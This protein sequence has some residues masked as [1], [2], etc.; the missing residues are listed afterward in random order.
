MSSIDQRIVEMKFDNKQFEKGIQTSLS[1]LSK[2]KNGLKFDKIKNGIN[3]T[4][5]S[6]KNLAHQFTLFGQ[7]ALKVKDTIADLVVNRGKQLVKSLTIDQVSSGWTKY[8][9]KTASVQT[10]MN[11]TGKSIDE[12]N[13]YLD[14]LMWFSDETSYSFTEM[15]SAL[16]TMTS[17]GGDINKLIPMIE[18][19]A[20]ATSFAGKGAAEFSRLIY[21]L[22]Q[23]YGQGYLSL[24]DWK[25]I[26][27]ANV[28]SEQ[29][30]QTI[31]DTAVALG[32]LKKD[33]KGVIRTTK[34]TV[35][36]AANMASTLNEKWATREVME[37]AFGQFGAVF[38]D[39]YELV[40]A[41]GGTAA[42]AIASLAG[43]YDDVYYNAAKAA[44]EAKTFTE[45]IVSTK[46][47]VSSGWMKTFEIIFGNYEEAKEM[48]TNLANFLWEAFASGSESRNK[49]M[50]EWKELG[51][52]DDLIKGVGNSL[53]AILNIV[54]A[55]K[56]GIAEIFPSPDAT[57]LVALTKKVKE[58]GDML[59]RLSGEEYSETEVEVPVKV[60]PDPEALKRT[61][62]RDM[63][64]DDVK[65]LQERLTSLGYSITDFELGRG[66]FGVAT[67]D[68]LKQF[69]KDLGLAA[70]GVYNEDVHEVLWNK[71]FPPTETTRVEKTIERVSVFSSALERLKRVA[72]GVA[73]AAD[74]LWKGIKFVGTVAFSVLKVLAPLADALLTILAAIGDCFVALD[75]GLGVSEL[76]SG[77]LA[78]I[79]G[80]LEPV[81]KGV[82]K[83]SDALL[84]FFGLGKKENGTN[85]SLMTFSKLW[86]NIKGKLKDWGVWD[87]LT[88]AW[89]RLSEAAGK[90]GNAFKRL[91]ASIKVAWQN[92]KATI[93]E[94]FPTLFDKTKTGAAN[95]WSKSITAIGIGLSKAIDFIT[96]IIQKLP[97]IKSKVTEFAKTA[98]TFLTDLWSRLE[99]SEKFGGIAARISNFFRTLWNAVSEFFIGGR[100]DTSSEEAKA[101][102]KLSI[103]AKIAETLKNGWDKVSS[104]FKWVYNGITT[105]WRKIGGLDGIIDNAWSLVALFG[106]FSGVK[107]LRS[108]SGFVKSISKIALG[109]PSILKKIPEFIENAGGVLESVSDYVKHQ[110]RKNALKN[111]ASAAKD[112]ALAIGIL[113][114]SIYVLGK[115]SPDELK[116][117]GIALAGIAFGLFLLQLGFAKLAKVNPDVKVQF[118]GFFSLALAVLT[119][120][121]V[122]KIINRMSLEDYLKGAARVAGMILALRLIMLGFGKFKKTNVSIKGMLSVSFALLALLRVMKIVN[123][124]KSSEYWTGLARVAGMILALRL[125]ML[126][127]GKFKKTNVS[128]KGL[129]SLSFSL[130]ALVGVIKL[131]SSMDAGDYW[132]GLLG[133]SGLMLALALFARS[134]SRLKTRG[135]AKKAVSLIAI[136]LTIRILARTMAYIGRLDFKT[137][138]LG[139]IGLTTIMLLLKAVMKA[140][141]RLNPKR[142]FSAIVLCLGIVALMRE[143]ARALRSVEDVDYRKTKW[144]GLGITGILASLSMVMR[145]S[146][147]FRFSGIAKIFLTIV[148]I[149]AAV[150]L[151]IA[152]FAELKKIPGFQE[153]MNSGAASL[154]EIV[155]SFLGGMH[156][157]EI[158]TF[159]NLANDVDEKA[160]ERALSLANKLSDFGKKLPSTSGESS[161]LSYFQKSPLAQFSGD[162]STFGK[163]FSEFAKALNDIGTEKYD[164]L[165]TKAGTA[166]DIA[167]SLAKF[168]SE[169]VEMPENT[170]S[171]PF[172]WIRES[173]LGVFSDDIGDF[174]GGFGT[175]ASM[176][177]LV[178]P[179]EYD[180]LEGKA[181]TALT[182]AKGLAAFSNENVEMPENTYTGPFGWIRKSSLE[183]FSEDFGD[184]GAEFNKFANKMSAVDA[185]DYD[186]LEGKA[187]TALTI[188]KGLAAFSNENVEMPENTYTG[189]FGWIRKSSLEIFSEDFGDFGAEFNKFANKMSAVDAADYDG[190]EGKASTALIIAKGLAAFSNE[191]VKAPIMINTGVFGWVHDSALEVFSEDMGD[192]G[193]GFNK[194]ANALNGVD[195]ASY[196]DLPKKA[197]T[198]LA[199]AKA[200]SAFTKEYVAPPDMVVIS[201]TGIFK[202]TAE[203]TTQVFNKDMASFGEAFNQFATALSSIEKPPTQEQVNTAVAC[204]QI[205]AT[206]LS[207]VS[208]M[209]LPS[210]KNDISVFL[211]GDTSIN[212]FLTKLVEFATSV[213]TAANELTGFSSD[214]STAKADLNVAVEF[215]ERMMGIMGQLCK[216]ASG[217]VTENDVDNLLKV[218]DHVIDS[219]GTIKDQLV[220]FNGSPEFN[221]IDALSIKLLLDSVSGL[222]RSVSGL[223][224]KTWLSD[225]DAD[226]I[227]EALA[228]FIKSIDPAFK[229]VK[230][231]LDDYVMNL[232]A[233]GSNISD[234]LTGIAASFN[235]AGKDYALGL[236]GNYEWYSE[237]TPFTEST[238]LQLNAVTAFKSR[239]R[240]AGQDFAIGLAKGLDDRK[241][242]VIKAAKVLAE[243]VL[244]KVREVFD[245]HSPSK[246]ANEI[247]RYFD[248][249]LVDGFRDGGS[250]TTRAAKEMA[251]DALYG[252][253]DTLL[254]LS[255]L[256]ADGIDVDPVIRPVVD[257]SGVTAGAQ[258]IGGMLGGSQTIPVDTSARL[259][260]SAARAAAA[261]AAARRGT[262]AHARSN[263]PQP[264]GDQVN[265][266]GNTFV[267]RDEQDIY[268][269][270]S[271]IA[272][273]MYRQQRSVGAY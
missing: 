156:S 38:Q 226:D 130:L 224:T 110:R 154:G 135:F 41:N 108:I 152:A 30:K 47:A 260:S 206:F 222:F 204:A 121:L 39:A 85:K 169:N 180:N 273:L 146:R 13:G 235:G 182:I 103:F 111:I 101:E 199:I 244:E 237:V 256:I 201:R 27:L 232:S 56:G 212:T 26:A 233:A 234:A 28:D 189:P 213:K 207:T 90:L 245:E 32:T 147:R 131:I 31:I 15:T 57:Q 1:S 150:G 178:T 10:I 230:A 271:E 228:D 151:V 183:I 83:A 229:D 9:Q 194:F 71:L 54:T 248:K 214:T 61:L 170:Y 177:N 140:A 119:L 3:E 216:N 86:G 258:A 252:V 22:N 251:L 62:K 223:N 5:E 175:F 198:A 142:A 55:L 139:L 168:S 261:S 66:Y 215:I 250:E 87:A 104:T 8:G 92:L 268:S 186:G 46:D 188:A 219:I 23:S 45:A 143:F 133:L 68:A 91:W 4:A 191:Y 185:A 65:A 118:R 122:M 14:K 20:A 93:G 84:D 35:V 253:K 99:V 211:S 163:K 53:R 29:L 263:T 36:T 155:G 88:S 145:H 266:T 63:A 269:L 127:F 144:F 210:D 221:D 124:F 52:R 264:A 44:Q 172:G 265:V 113:V 12:V 187:S 67:R 165:E 262:E 58:F 11:A 174:A 200:L 106:A 42:D 184:F 231:K 114:A 208:K 16:G 240:V 48:W 33:S 167:K 37:Q 34:K 246:E 138:A 95:L 149:V 2:L 218:L 243:G 132:S 97:A 205:V 64:G 181:S 98:W 196:D 69:Q 162:M 7:I 74:I 100:G 94:K 81:A 239:F 272:S 195:A 157:A 193:S 202:W 72:R 123:Q 257:L 171:G 89:N 128:I 192:F 158:S 126:G 6:V 238:Q 82:R 203:S 270:A 18:G 24:I 164:D 153:F 129:L 134:L 117:G 43:K 267:I 125:I 241:Q 96:S 254:A 247:G 59:L 73:A 217:V 50:E 190:L 141:A 176:M 78:T 259:A 75:K 102:K 236:A 120:V 49:L 148:S 227:T 60:N 76:F 116:R 21:N 80:W 51:G 70:D 179:A 166:L 40:Q 107:L 159:N 137:Y 25:S 197:G 255:T 112:F 79:I 209:N 220:E 173:A 105:L 136:A 19:M 160:L 161:I 109:I 249:G 17:S 77:V 225:L 242:Y 115:M